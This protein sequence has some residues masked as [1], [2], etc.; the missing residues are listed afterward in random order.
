VSK[1]ILCLYLHGFGS[2][3]NCKKSNELAAYFK[4]LPVLIEFVA[5]TMSEW[6]L[7]AIQDIEEVIAKYPT[8]QLCVV[9]S[10]LGGYYAMEITERHACKT[11]L[12]NPML[13]VGCGFEEYVG[14]K[15][16]HY[17]KTIE[18]TPKHVEQLKQLQRNTLKTPENYYVLLQKDDNIINYRHAFEFFKEAKTAVYSGGG[19]QFSNFNETLNHIAIFFDIKTKGV[20]E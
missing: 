11:V 9:G 1:P 2:S 19:H 13:S 14:E 5:P 20:Y 12:I 10:S 8:H 3:P 4:T 16:M 7:K 15:A 18:I 6:P 17:E